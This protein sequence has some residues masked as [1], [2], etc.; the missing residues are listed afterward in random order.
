GAY[1]GRLC[2]DEFLGI[3][4][5]MGADNELFRDDGTYVPVIS[6][7]AGFTPVAGS[8]FAYCCKTVQINGAPWFAIGWNSAAVNALQI[9][10]NLNNPPT[11]STIPVG[12]YEIA[13]LC[14]TP[15]DGDAMQIYTADATGGI[16]K[17]ISMIPAAGTVAPE[18]AV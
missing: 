11:S 14:Q 2:G 12:A 15:I 1:G 17:R 18:N 4:L 13:G 9:I 8:S 6:T 5:M 16:I 7:V 3:P 10:S